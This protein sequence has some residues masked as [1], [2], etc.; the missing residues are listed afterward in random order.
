[1]KN[2]TLTEENKLT[3]DLENIKPNE[4]IFHVSG[5]ET[6]ILRLCR[7]GDIYIR[8]KLAENDKEIVGAMREYLKLGLKIWKK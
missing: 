5:S 3:I 6:P 2:K 4:I 7:D 1:M 8:G